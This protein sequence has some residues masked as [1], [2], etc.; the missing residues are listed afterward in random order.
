MPF[1]RRKLLIAIMSDVDDL[2]GGW[3]P[4]SSAPSD[5][6]LEVDVM[7]QR[8]VFTLV[9]PV[10]KDGDDWVDAKTKKRVDISPTHWRVW[11]VA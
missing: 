4:I 1:K 10:R 6:D 8:D 9:F 2:P 11:R 3:L 5:I 7:D